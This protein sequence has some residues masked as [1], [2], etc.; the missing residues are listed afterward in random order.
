M[1]VIEKLESLLNAANATTAAGDAD[2]TAAVASL[3]AGYGGGGEAQIATGTFIRTPA[4]MV[5]N[6][7][8]THN[9]GKKPKIIV[10]WT[11][12]T[13]TINA[14]NVAVKINGDT[15]T[16][17]GFSYEGKTALS[18]TSNDDDSTK[19]WTPN[20]INGTTTQQYFFTNTYNWAAV[21]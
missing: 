19:F 8:I 21:G 2:L 13:T 7:D 5:G 1:T 9:L 6:F 3:I 15:T 18:G 10:I 11:N 20:L 4:T 12:A 17:F 14:I 16:Q